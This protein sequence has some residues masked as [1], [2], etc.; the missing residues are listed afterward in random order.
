MICGKCKQEKNKDLFS[1]SQLNRDK[2]R[3][4]KPICKSCVSASLSATRKK[5]Q[6]KIE[7]GEFVLC[8][9]CQIP[10]TVNNCYS[11]TNRCA[12]C[13]KK[14]V[15]AIRAMRIASDKLRIPRKC[16]TCKQT[17]QGTGAD[18]FTP[19]QPRCKACNRELQ[20]ENRAKKYGITK[21]QVLA[22]FGDTPTCFICKAEIKKTKSIHID[23]CHKTGTVRGILCNTCNVGI[24]L[25]KEDVQVLQSA[26][27]YLKGS[28]PNHVA[29]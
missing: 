17:K 4:G 7:S 24:G 11:N 26:I 29:S 10:L 5:L 8:R 21:E 19:G 16:C 1:A 3:Y 9:K 27:M 23:H 2:K 22:L 28:E 12:D 14:D 18:G 20:L 6:T 25:L 15:S 13:C